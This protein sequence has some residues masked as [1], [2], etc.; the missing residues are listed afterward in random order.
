MAWPPP[1]RSRLLP[2][3]LLLFISLPQYS[4]AAPSSAVDPASRNEY[5]RVDGSLAVIGIAMNATIGKVHTAINSMYGFMPLSVD[6]RE[7]N[8]VRDC[9]ELLD[10]SAQEL[11]WSLSKLNELHSSSSSSDVVSWLS[12]AFGNQDTCL[13]G[14]AGTRSQ[15][16]DYIKV[17]LDQITQ[18]VGS[19]LAM[20]RNVHTL[21][22]EPETPVDIPGDGIADADGFP[23]W[24]Q[25][26]DRQ[27][28]H[29]HPR[30]L[31]FDA[32]VAMDDSG[33][34]SSIMEAINAAPDHSARKY[35]IHVKRGVYR[36]YVQIKKKKTNI[37]LIGEGVG[38][39]VISGDRSFAQ[40]FTTFR[41]A[42]FAV[43]GL[44]FIARD[45]TFRN[46]AGPQNGQA[47]AL[48]VDSDRSAFFRCSIEGYQ[49]TLYS[50]SLRQ[51]Y[52]D[53]SI[54]GTVDFIFGNG[55]AVF[56]NCNIYARKPLPNQKIS[57]TAQGRKDANQNTGFV[58]QKS[59]LFPTSDLARVSSAYPAYLGRPWKPYARTVFMQTYMGNHIRPEGWLEW[60][61]HPY[62]SSVYY[63]EYENSGPGSNLR[64]RVKWP[65]FHAIGSEVQARAFTVGTFLDGRSWLPHTG[66]PFTAGF[67][68]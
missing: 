60:L 67:N 57:I 8:A 13:E 48:R 25:D 55:A 18:V 22:I 19:M 46:T 45:I 1:S 66:V 52:R 37:V 28:L 9:I 51:F 39:T 42:T 65:G 47:V 12:A 54:Y 34:H 17:H 56:Q 2:L 43:S 63:A 24:F 16:G 38:V 53:C 41:T 36:E 11:T 27:I 23:D 29:R 64:G 30:R 4:S 32:V 58:I 3:A 26:D 44:G 49:D 33:N 6:Q 62:D 7:Q 50:H 68:K 21:P 59:G 15:V 61:G 10:L 35:V 40:G 14:F 5:D 20:V 31:R